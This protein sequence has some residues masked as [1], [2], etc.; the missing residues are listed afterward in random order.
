MKHMEHMYLIVVSAVFLFGCLCG[1]LIFSAI[2]EDC[3]TRDELCKLDIKQIASL[4][5]Q[6]T[7]SEN[8][9]FASIDKSLKRC[10][11]QQVELCKDKVKRLEDACNDLDCAQCRR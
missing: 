10:V 3:K 9:C 11:K 2:S 7:E 4:K 1:A 6:L 5:A 8:K